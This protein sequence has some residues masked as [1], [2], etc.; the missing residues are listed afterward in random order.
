MLWGSVLRSLVH[1]IILIG[2]QACML[3]YAIHAV[4][5]CESVSQ[6][7]GILGGAQHTQLPFHMKAGESFARMKLLRTFTVA[8]LVDYEFRGLDT[9][10]TQTACVH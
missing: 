1:L 8:H 4:I 9:N 7:Y 2:L 5:L 6:Q 10:C 3:T